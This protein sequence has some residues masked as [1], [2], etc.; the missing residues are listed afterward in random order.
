MGGT[1][2]HREPLILAISN[3]T[4][5]ILAQAGWIAYFTRIQPSNEEI[6]IEFL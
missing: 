4:K 1:T 3:A 2:V 6:A 5:E